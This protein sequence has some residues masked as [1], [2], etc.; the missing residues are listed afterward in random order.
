MAANGIQAAFTFD[1]QLGIAGFEMVPELDGQL[2]R[3]GPSAS[4]CSPPRAGARRG[5]MRSREKP[6]WPKWRQDGQI[7]AGHLHVHL[8]A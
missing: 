4:R 3:A 6:S 5:L 8:T 2:C 1:M 7:D